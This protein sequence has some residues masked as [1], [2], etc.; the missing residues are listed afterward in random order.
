VNHIATGRALS[1][2]GEL[3]PPLQ[4][5]QFYISK[6][7]TDSLHK[8]IGALFR[9]YM[10]YIHWLRAKKMSTKLYVNIFKIH[11]SPAQQPLPS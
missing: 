11:L 3:L 7:K 6:A 4:E 2:E 10:S 9:E 1:P 8:I 5:H